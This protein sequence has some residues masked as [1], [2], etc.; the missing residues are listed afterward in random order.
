METHRFRGA[1]ARLAMAA[2]V[3]CAALSAAKAEPAPPLSVLLRQSEASAPRLAESEANIRAAQGAAV[4]AAVRPNPTV[5]LLDE[6]I[7]RGT[8]P[9][10]LS[11]EQT[12]L[13]VNQPLE[14]GGQ[15]GPRIAAAGAG[16]EAARAQR[17]VTRS[18]FGY[19]LAVAYATAELNARRVTLAEESL[20][21]AQE[22]E[23][24]ARALVA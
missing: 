1:S 3:C 17:E 6:N 7:G 2:V 13:S 19:D 15:R 9:N 14:I 10:G 12:T 4:Q 21:R 18:D 20:A 24:A 5:S 22:D 23:R 8:S 16:V 11:Q